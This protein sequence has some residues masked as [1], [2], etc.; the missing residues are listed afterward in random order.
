MASKKK[1]VIAGATG[2]IGQELGIA[3]VRKGF[4]ISVLT[5]DPKKHEGRLAFPCKLL[6]FD[7]EQMAAAEQAI[8]GA[9]AVIN[10]V[11]QSI[12][13]GTWKLTGERSVY[14]SRLDPLELLT[15]AVRKA[16]VPPKIFLQAS[17][18]GYYGN[19]QDLCTEEHPPA[20]ES[21]SFLA[22]VCIDLENM[23]RRVESSGTRFIPMRIGVVLGH[24]GALEK[25]NQLYAAGAGARFLGTKGF[26]P[27]VAIDDV[28]AAFIFVVEHADV[29]DIKGP[30]NIVGPTIATLSDLH[31]TMVKL[32]GRQFAPPVPAWIV[33]KVANKRAVLLF[34]SARVSPKKLIDC[35][36]D[37]AVKTI[38]QAIDVLC[39]A[40]YKGQ[41]R[42][43]KKQFVRADMNEIWKFFS[44]PQN[45]EAITPPW[46]CFK[47][48]DISTEI[49]GNGT[50]IHYQ[51]TLKG[52]PITW[53]SVISGYQ[54]K[55]QFKD[56]QLVGPYEVWEHTHKFEPLGDGVLIIDDIVYSLPFGKSGTM[57]ASWYVQKDVS[58]IFNFRA[59]VVAKKLNVAGTAF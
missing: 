36:F 35:G 1:I 11:G 8:D 51:L 40:G 49:M 20:S 25:I 37:F 45:L 22:K 33:R 31:A 57:V 29:K 52:V 43:V 46:L 10:L 9:Y 3:L 18:T 16:K 14:A 24:G 54:E 6:T 28:V 4:E 41:F 48:K 27:W 53:K 17:A 39:P 34:D 59:D 21:E 47:I 2:F 5:R 44:M 23:G 32:H 58:Q 13:T 15:S 26:F 38:D 19:S 30:I 7:K 12:D 42:L 55:K 50:R 56:E